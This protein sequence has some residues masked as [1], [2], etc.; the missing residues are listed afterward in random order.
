ML[1]TDKAWEKWGR[2]DPYYAVLAD[3]KFSAANIAAN[4][5]EFFA[6]GANYVSKLLAKWERHFGPLNRG[7]ALDYGCGVGR[8]TLPL[9]KA[10]EEVVALDISQSMLVEGQANAE[11]AQI[12]NI[13]FAIADDGLSAAPGPFDFV[14]CTIVLQHIRVRRGLRI[15][16]GLVD[17][18]GD[19][20]GFHIHFST[21]H[22]PWR[23]RLLWWASQHLPGVK[24][25][26]NVMRGWRWSQPSM[27]MNNYRLN[28]ILLGLS[29][30]GIV[31]LLVTSEMHDK[32][33]TCSI[34]G[35]K[36]VAQSASS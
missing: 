14:T 15:L 34:I 13:R 18:L 31:E 4:R 22:D 8:L 19:G 25:V 33:L 17:R 12:T 6:S 7:R 11:R 24:G 32:F 27:Q 21:R 9:A 5:E 2:E 26:Q 36:P 29:Q 3:E 30:R 35:R 16:F 20:G 23:S 1:S 28:R 10:F